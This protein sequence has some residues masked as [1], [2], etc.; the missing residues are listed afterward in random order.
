VGPSIVSRAYRAAQ[1][2]GAGKRSAQDDETEA[3][4]LGAGRASKVKAAGEGGE[5]A[6]DDGGG[7]G[8]PADEANRRGRR[9]LLSSDASTVLSADDSTPAG[10][11]TSSSLA[12]ASIARSHASR[13]VW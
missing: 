4:A 7:D 2:E 5:G 6:R 3:F 8:D 11:A 9:G 10:G 1:P 13:R 12:S